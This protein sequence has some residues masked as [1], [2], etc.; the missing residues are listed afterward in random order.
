MRN[1]VEFDFDEVGSIPVLE[2]SSFSKEIALEK[3]QCLTFKAAGGP[4]RV[5]AS[6]GDTIQL[7]FSRFKRPDTIKTEM[8]LTIN[9]EKLQIGGSNIPRLSFYDSIVRKFGI[10]L[11]GPNNPGK[12][13]ISQKRTLDSIYKLRLA[14][15]NYYVSKYHLS[16]DFKAIAFLEIKG[17][18]LTELAARCFMFKRNQFPEG[19]FSALNQENFT[20][21]NCHKSWLYTCAARSYVTYYLRTVPFGKDAPEEKLQDQYNIITT[22]LKDIP[23]RD[24][25]LTNV[26]RE[27]IDN[28]PNNFKEVFDKYLAV[29]ANP[30]YK[31]ALQKQY[32]LSTEFVHEPIPQ[33]ILNKTIFIR[34]TDHSEI[35]LKS[36]I[37]SKKFDNILIDFWA[38]WCKPCLH[39]APFLSA[40]EEQFKDKVG[41]ISVS[42]DKDYK[43]FEG[44]LKTFNLSGEQYYLKD[45][46]SS[47]LLKYLKLNAIPRY[48]I[49]DNEFNLLKFKTP[50]PEEKVEFEKLLTELP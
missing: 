12:D 47:P 28:Q 30:S 13:P 14:Y 24:Y 42:I 36:L 5:I 2:D 18:Y 3:T 37:A 4:Y 39:Q 8:G 15:L 43:A 1:P 27:Y 48:I 38:S 10:L 44:G 49:V 20:W 22:S 50:F 40:F 25:F 26:I 9:L 7:Y 21:E 16:D 23:L 33:N 11:D 19:Y 6:L 31:E 45:Y 17:S 29:C 35:S 41:F 32:R 46:G 34:S